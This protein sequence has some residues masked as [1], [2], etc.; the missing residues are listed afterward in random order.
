M[1]LWIIVFIV[2]S[3]QLNLWS[4]SEAN[5]NVILVNKYVAHEI[6]LE[7]FS[8]KVIFLE[9][10]FHCEHFE[11]KVLIIPVNLSI[12]RWKSILI[13]FWFWITSVNLLQ[14]KKLFSFTI[15]NF[16][17][18]ILKSKIILAIVRSWRKVWIILL[19]RAIKL[20]NNG[21]KKCSLKLKCDAWV[22]LSKKMRIV[23]LANLSILSDSLRKSD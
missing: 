19:F 7:Y 11:M 8:L 21:Q 3:E 13:S 22:F 18:V 1:R 6:D 23:G 16:V 17:L 5:E 12:S 2:N 14:T 10:Y 15:S 9:N 20:F 4:V